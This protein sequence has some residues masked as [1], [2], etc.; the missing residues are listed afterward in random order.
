MDRSF[1][2]DRWQRNQLGFHE[3]QVNALLVRHF[4]SL[5]LA[6]GKRVFVPLCG[7]SLD[8]AWLL[9]RGHPVAGVELSAIAVEQLFAGLGVRPDV[10]PLGS[11]VHYAA[12]GIEIFQG[13]LFD[14]SREV[15]GQV[16][17]IYDRAA[18]IAL[19]EPLRSR[20]A[21]HLQ[22]LTGCAPQ[23][24]ITLNYDPQHLAGPPFAVD[25]AEVARLYQGAYHLQLLA[26]APVVGGLKGQCPAAEEVWHLRAAP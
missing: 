11:L 23:L 18:L 8:I 13:D 20:Y 9:G 15:L 22:Q 6:P 1:W 19:P 4:A 16:D 14:L 26:S 24:L 25:G 10:R 21:R 2:L 7:K 17:A 5:S 3:A 12:A